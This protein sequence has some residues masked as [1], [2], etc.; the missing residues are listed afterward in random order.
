M[1]RIPLI[2]GNEVLPTGPVAYGSGD[3][4]SVTVDLV[5]D[6]TTVGTTWYDFQ[7]NGT[8]GHMIAIDDSGWVHMVWMNGLESGAVHRHVYYNVYMGVGGW[9]QP[10]VGVAVESQTRAGYTCLSMYPGSYVIPAFHVITPSS[11]MNGQPHSAVSADYIPG[12]G[13]FF[14]PPWELP[15]VVAGD[16]TLQLIWPKIAVDHQGQVHVVSSEQP[17]SGAGGDPMRVY[18]CRGVF[19]P[20]IPSM[21]FIPQVFIGWTETVAADVAAS[22]HSNRVAVSVHHPRSF[23]AAFVQNNNDVYLYESED[24][25]TWDWNHPTN[26]TNFLP[27]PRDSLRAYCD[28]SILYDYGDNLH[29]AFTVFTADTVAGTG[30]YNSQIYHWAVHNGTGYYSLVANGYFNIVSA[31]TIAWAPPGAWQNFVQRPCLAVDEATGH[32]FITYIQYDTADVSSGGYPNG[33]VMVSRSTDDGCRWSVGTNI[34]GTTNDGAAAG[35]CWNERE[36]TCNE[37]V[38]DGDLHILYVLDKDAGGVVS[39]PMEGA[40]TL[41][42]TKYHRVSINDI[43]TAPLMRK[44][45]L[46]ADSAGFPPDSGWVPPSMG[47]GL[48]DGAEIPSRF[49]LAQ[50][51]PNPFNPTTMI[52]FD[53]SR[54]DKVTLKVYNIIGQQVATLV[55]GKLQAGTY[56]VPFDADNLASGV[57]FYKLSSSVQSETRK[58]VL[59]K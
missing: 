58:M 13:A 44:Y 38:V 39:T 46:H 8:C 37:T 32:L 24:G 19:D 42:P 15:Y 33:E 14:Q 49:R 26:V 30:T 56:Q 47:V 43:S 36:A 12:A 9:L 29:V 23:P 54:A 3:F 5:G 40:W 1:D 57:Y 4:A 7:H 6:T 16:T 48:T 10:G 31:E 17:Q 22:R 28:A 50:N 53:L 2:T 20:A 35:D 51:Y 55:D 59:L 21:T 45:P 18:Y 34:T 27:S 11:P 52:H 25:I 41:N